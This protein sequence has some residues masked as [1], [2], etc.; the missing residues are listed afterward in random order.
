MSSRLAGTATPTDRQL[1]QLAIRPSYS[2]RLSARWKPLCRGVCGWGR[3]QRFPVWPGRMVSRGL[4]DVSLVVLGTANVTLH[5]T[6]AA[7]VLLHP[8]STGAYAV[9]EYTLRIRIE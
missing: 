3:R 1:V 5:V 6:C 9:Y 2:P 4:V 7:K 8:S